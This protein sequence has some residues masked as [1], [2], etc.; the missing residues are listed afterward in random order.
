M[1]VI[2]CIPGLGADKRLFRNLNL[3]GHDIHFL[4][5]IPHRR[6]ETITDYATRLSMQIEH[7]NPILIGVSLGGIMSVEIS[8][9]I[10][11]KKVILISSLKGGS[12][13]PPY[14]HTQ[15]RFNFQRIL[16]VGFMKRFACSLKTMKGAQDP[17]DIEIFRSMI[18]GTNSQ[19]FR[20]AIGQVLHWEHPGVSAPCA[21]FHGANDFLIPHKNIK[22]VHLLPAESHFMFSEKTHLLE[23]LIRKEIDM[24]T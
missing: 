14:M 20:W 8:S 4:E 18:H 12:E 21:H 6:R 10:D 2:Y 13:R 16:P 5:W 7:P 11:V 19:F 15:K 17:N 24:M 3:N 1:A 22:D 9:I 23:P